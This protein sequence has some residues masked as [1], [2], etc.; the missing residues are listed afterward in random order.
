MLQNKKNKEDKENDDADL[1]CKLLAKQLKD[2]PKDE[3]EEIMYEIHGLILDKRRRCR[4]RVSQPSISPSIYVRS[5][6]AHSFTYSNE[7]PRNIIPPDQLIVQQ[8]SLYVDTPPSQIVIN[9]PSSSRSSYNIT[10]PPQNFNKQRSHQTLPV[11]NQQP[12]L[13]CYTSPPHRPSSSRSSYRTPTPPQNFEQEI[14]H[15]SPFISN[16][17]QILPQETIQ[18]ETNILLEAFEKATTEQN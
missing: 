1:F 17:V 11:I 10:T 5:S 13:Y 14:S 18:P 16:N 2:F 6:S 15:E 8:P 9:R 3:R 7:S 12:T 4:D